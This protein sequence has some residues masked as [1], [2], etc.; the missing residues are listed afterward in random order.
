[1]I[2][3]GVAPSTRTT[4]ST[5]LSYKI[6]RGNNLDWF[7]I[8]AQT[9]AIYVNQALDRETRDVVELVVSVEEQGRIGMQNMGR[10]DVNIVIADCNDNTP[11]FDEINPVK[12]MNENLPVGS[13]V[14]RVLASDTDSGDNGYISYSIANTEPVPFTI[15]HFTG[16]VTVLESLDFE[17]MKR[18]YFLHI[19]ASDWGAPYRREAENVLKLQ[20]QD[21][22]DN[23]PGFETVNC[24]GHLSREAGV[25]TTVAAVSA[26]DFDAG[27]IISYE[28]VSG[29]SDNCFEMVSASGVI[30][31]ACDLRQ[32][33][34]GGGGSGGAKRSL[35]VRANDGENYS[36]LTT[37]NITLVSN[38]RNRALANRDSNVAC[39][40]TDIVRAYRQQLH[41]SERNN[42]DSSGGGAAHDYYI[43]PIV[44][45]SMTPTF[46]RATRDRVTIPEDLALR[47]LV[48]KFSAVDD[49]Q[50]YNG[51]L[52]YSI[53][54]GN[55]DSKF[56]ISATSG[57]MYVIAALDREQRSSYSFN[58]K[59]TDMGRPAKKAN[60]I[61]A[62]D[63]SDVNDNAP[64]FTQ[65]SY[66]VTVSESEVAGASIAAVE[67]RDVDL[68]QNGVV[69]Y[70]IA[71]DSSMFN[72]D[73]VNGKI[74]IREQLDRE[75]Q[76][77]YDVIVQAQDSGTPSLTSTVSVKVK[78]DDVN[79][80]RPTFMPPHYSVRVR[81]DLPVGTVVTAIQAHDP[82]LRSGGVV[83]YHLLDGHSDA[84][85]VD[86][87][88]GIIRIV[89]AL[90]YEQRQIYNISAR[91]RDRGSPALFS[92]CRVI[93]EVVDVNENLFTPTFE[94]YV[95]TAQVAENEAR[96]TDVT[97]LIAT[98]DDVTNPLASARD[99]DVMYAI[100]DGDGLGK[101]S[102]DNT[103]TYQH[104]F[105][106]F[107][108]PAQQTFMEKEHF[109]LFLSGKNLAS[110]DV[111]GVVSIFM[112]F[113]PVAKTLQTP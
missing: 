50:G 79:D 100:V 44:Q 77:A 87:E 83:R 48:T 63:V 41:E 96:G 64:Q 27:N 113:K 108:L 89:R 85:A 70:S 72:I 36:D 5:R 104:C 10:S 30:K 28:I 51:L 46:P 73:P 39:S 109:P 93:V 22:N 68:D 7:A 98:D 9:G 61:F 97:Q 107:V 19:R 62:V 31:T 26:I 99:Y 106:S 11:T 76:D 42:D 1:M 2:V 54:E 4:S 101:F 86:S 59:V 75:T 20:L 67:A 53:V 29:N 78:V 37:V 88:T 102:I 12:N 103:G 58:I 18:E 16:V 95:F 32:T 69:R 14:Y 23:R 8:N 80:N 35:V 49:D 25:G 13:S 94:K 92:R 21:V 90:D 82:D 71:S 6:L 43:S 65:A 38:K 60:H 105:D 66:D 15:D 40:G 57:E 34:S 74:Y 24:D 112:K 56:N 111:I 81:E 45:N 47:G 84:F 17:T 52:L 110:C 33:A 55:E 3:A 91:A